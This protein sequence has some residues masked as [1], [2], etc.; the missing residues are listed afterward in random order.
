MVAKIATWGAVCA[1]VLSVAMPGAASASPVAADAAARCLV[2]ADRGAALA[3]FE[4]LPLDSSMTDVDATRLGAGAK[5][6]KGGLRASAM[7]MRG[8]VAEALYERDFREAGLQ[9]RRAIGDFAR[10]GLP[11]GVADTGGL[12]ALGHCVARSAP[13]D[14]DKLFAA[15][16]GSTREDN[17]IAA[18][19]PYFS[20][21]QPKGTEV[22]LRRG[23]IRGLLAQSAYDVNVRYW[24]GQMRAARAG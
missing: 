16:P 22:A 8:A 24:T 21:C 1:G 6:V 17:V 20:A 18:L 23:Q 5:C 19:M 10:L 7:V 9:P 11:E 14:V 3:L 4:R 13:F 2:V 12:F 15:P